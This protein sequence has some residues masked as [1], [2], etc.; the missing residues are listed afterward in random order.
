MKTM[1]LSSIYIYSTRLFR[2]S[3]WHFHHLRIEVMGSFT[4]DKRTCLGGRF[5]AMS[6]LSIPMGASMW[7]GGGFEARGMHGMD[8]GGG[9]S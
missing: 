4:V 9:L 1:L 3:S 5:G 7:K 2:R 6:N 8:C